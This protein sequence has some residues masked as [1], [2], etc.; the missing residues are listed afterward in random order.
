MIKYFC[1]RCGKEGGHSPNLFFFQ[2]GKFKVMVSSCMKGFF[3]KGSWNL[4]M[5]CVKEIVLKG[6]IA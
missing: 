2:I 4:C 3:R 5:E 1:D 6:D